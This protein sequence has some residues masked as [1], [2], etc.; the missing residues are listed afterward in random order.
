MSTST[1]T[2][3][4][5]ARRPLFWALVAALPVGLIACLYLSPSLFD[6]S[7]EWA[8]GLL[9][10]TAQTLLAV[11]IVFLLDTRRSIGLLFGALAFAW[12][13]LVSTPLAMFVNTAWIA[14]LTKAG[15]GTVSA[16]MVA[17]VDEELAKAVGALLVLALLLPRRVGPLQGLVVGFLVGAGFEIAENF[18]YAMNAASAAERSQ[19][20]PTVID[21]FVL[22]STE[23]LL[24][25]ALWTGVIAAGIGAAV[26]AST[27]R[28][29]SVALLTTAGLLLSTMLF[30]G[31]W[32]LPQLSTSSAEAAV[33][34]ALLYSTIVA[35]FLVVWFVG[36]RRDRR[37]RRLERP[38]ENAHGPR[39][40]SST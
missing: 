12:G 14:A 31:L 35:V 7:P 25:H 8:L 30:H 36:W 29:R 16:A 2:P 9:L 26:G 1:R 17:P 33:R 18:S 4:T 27:A 24:L 40:L 20:L 37:A 6:P 28:A 21:T 34:G 39:S 23:G 11:L 13:V 3:T 10:A 15:L 5:L 19:V 32:D 38:L 22:R